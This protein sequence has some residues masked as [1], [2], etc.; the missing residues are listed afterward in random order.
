MQRKIELLAPAKNLEFGKIAISHGADAVY[1]GAPKFGARYNAGNSISDIDKLTKYAH[2]YNSKVYVTLNTLLFDNEIEEARTLCYDL[3]S[4]GIDAL[5]I[6]DMALL[7]IDLP[8]IK[9]HAST[10]T[11][12]YDLERVKFLSKCGFERIILARELSIDAIKE[13]HNNTECELES[14]IH[15]ALCVC[16]SGQCY[17]SYILNKHS[18]NRGNCSQPCRSSYDLI[19]SNKK[20]LIHNSHLLSIKDLNASKYVEELINAGITSLK[21]E[22]RLKDQTYLKNVTA[23][24][25]ILLDN[26]FENNNNNTNNPIYKASSSGKTSFN[27]VPDLERSFNRGYTNY[28]LDNKRKKIGSHATQKSLG[29][30][31]GTVI[32]SN[33]K[34]IIIDSQYEI[35]NGDGLCYFD[36]NNTLTGF[37]VNKVIENKIFP[38]KQINIPSKTELFRNHDIKFI[39]LLNTEN[40]SNRKIEAVIK[41]EEVD[42]KILFTII[43]EDNCKADETL[44]TNYEIAKNKEQSINTLKI[45]LNKLN[46]TPFILKNISINL[47]NIY[48]LPINIINNVRR[49]LVNKLIEKRIKHF[50]QLNIKSNN[51]NISHL[52]NDIYIKKA[53]FTLNITNQYSLDFYKK[54]NLKEFD[55]GLEAT[56]DT[57]NKIVMRTKYCIKYE[58]EQC[59]VY[60]KQDNDFNQDLFLKNGKNI[61][62]LEFDCK[63]CQ[64]Y[65]KT[66]P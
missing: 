53:D 9:L 25:R 60:F 39:K 33:P 63:K 17:L 8:P 4:C 30:K 20:T 27:F 14:F 13:I 21:I 10:Q 12:N 43:D 50:E 61:L 54:H 6:Q 55:F 16:F 35:C 58:L 57:K 7:N 56:N 26:I 23:Y 51:K 2:I 37:Y 40:T 15:G 32:R 66:L 31:I 49:S 59:P 65:I 5:I 28:F 52:K 36:K 34:Y 46:S 44:D 62:K 1:I 48:F 11:D 42:S 19:N 45:Q 47:N 22:G 24:Y 38:N 29:K 41:I 64:M 3:Y 18:G